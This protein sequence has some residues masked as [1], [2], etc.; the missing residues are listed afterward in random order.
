MEVNNVGVK[1]KELIA[2]HPSMTLN[3]SGAV[4]NLRKAILL[5]LML[6]AAGC[7]SGH[8][9]QSGTL[10]ISQGEGG[11]TIDASAPPLELRTFGGGKI[12]SEGAPVTIEKGHLRCVG[13]A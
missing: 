6:L 8:S 9:E 11:V 4:H 3:R 13:Q 5:G 10:K 7:G 2:I 1:T 12:C